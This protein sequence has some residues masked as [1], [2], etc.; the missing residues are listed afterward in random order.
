MITVV[1]DTLP[2]KIPV[3]DYSVAGESNEGDGIDDKEILDRWTNRIAN[4]V[5]SILGT[6]SIRAQVKKEFI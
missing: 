1:E 3:N 5:A 2:A 4:V 6:L